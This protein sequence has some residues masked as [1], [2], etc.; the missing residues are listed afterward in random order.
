MK[1]TSQLILWLPQLC[2]TNLFPLLDAS[3]RGRYYA[4]ISHHKRVAIGLRGILIH[5]SCNAARNNLAFSTRFSLI[6]RFRAVV[7][8]AFIMSPGILVCIRIMKW[9]SCNNIIQRYKETVGKA[10]STSTPLSVSCWFCNFLT[11]A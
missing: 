5:H 10:V 1:L 9:L 8:S 2:M 6:G 11:F 7:G 4:A 3:L